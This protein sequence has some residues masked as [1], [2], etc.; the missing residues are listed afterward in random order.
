MK[1]MFLGLSLLF[2]ALSGAEVV[3]AQTSV[4]FPPGR[5]ATQEY[6]QHYV[7]SVLAARP[8][9]VQPPVV[10]IPEGPGPIVPVLLPCEAGPEIRSIGGVTE[11]S[12]TVVFHGSKV[13][14]M[15]YTILKDGLPQRFGKIKP[16]SNT[17]T[18]GYETLP[19]G[20]YTLRLSGNTC[21]GISEPKEFT[22]EKWSG[23]VNPPKVIPPGGVPHDGG[24]TDQTVKP[25]LLS[26]AHPYILDVQ[27]AGSSNDW[28]ISDVSTFGLR[29]GYEFIYLVNNDVV[30]TDRPLK[31]YHYRGNAPVRVHKQPIKKG[32]ESL[33]KWD[34]NAKPGDWFLA[35]ASYSFPPISDVGGVTSYYFQNAWQPQSGDL[36]WVNPVPATWVPKDYSTWPDVSPEITLPADKVYVQVPHTEGQTIARSLRLGVTHIS[37]RWVD[38]EPNLPRDHLY[39]DVPQTRYLLNMRQA[40]DGQWVKTFTESEARAA[41]RSVFLPNLWVGETMEGD[42][43]VEP[44]NPAWTWFYDEVSKR[45][46]ELYRQDG[47]RRYVAHNYYDIL[48][49]ALRQHS[50]AKVT[51]LRFVYT[52][53]AR[54][55]PRGEFGTTLAQTNTHLTGW[56]KTFP[57]DNDYVYKKLYAMQA[58]KRLGLFT[59]VFLFPVHEWQPGFSWQV[60]VAAP[61]GKFSRSDKAPISP[62]ELVTAAYLGLDEGDIAIVWDTDAWMS[63]N[64]GIPGSRLKKPTNYSSLEKR[65]MNNRN[66]ILTAWRLGFIVA[67][68]L[69]CVTRPTAW[70]QS[71]AEI[72]RTAYESAL[73][74]SVLLYQALKPVHH[75]L[76]NAY[77]AL[78]VEN[79]A[80]RLQ[81]RFVAL[82]AQIKEQTYQA[83]MAR[84]EKRR[85]RQRWLDRGIGFGLGLL[86]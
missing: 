28:T 64:P 22:I 55:L 51:D 33:N 37:Q 7:D 35:D 40:A 74:D 21:Q 2:V 67:A 9:V 34:P 12:L 47:K 31:D 39:N 32:V 71:S 23:Q 68:M 70:A 38:R 26:R 27:I 5:L 16:E 76:E 60:D 30:R 50:V 14:G 1:R 44:S 6:V 13:F 82:Q 43:W 18:I 80:L 56:Y 24:K 10:I 52:S 4:Y 77:A 59:G 75:S 3:T 41:G 63:K 84:L 85:K 78:K 83:T 58:S 20:T 69:L 61:A 81:L 49:M 57:D 53:P 29:P 73:L 62:G 48:P 45:Y 72:P 36:A 17:L 65:S 42:F 11:Q 25:V 46:R 79:Q 54:N 86:F 15:D 19:A 8:V 66:S